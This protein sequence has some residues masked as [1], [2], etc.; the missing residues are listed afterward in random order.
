MKSGNPF[1]SHE[2]ATF[3]TAFTIR[4]YLLRVGKM[5]DT[6]PPILTGLNLPESVN[7]NSSNPS[8][9][10]TVAATDDISGV[11]SVVVFLD[12]AISATDASGNVLTLQGFYLPRASDGSFTLTEPLSPFASPGTYHVSEIQVQD[13]AGN[14][15]DYR[16]TDLAAL[17]LNTTFTLSGSTD[18]LS[19]VPLDADKNEGNSGSTPFTFTVSR[20]GDT[21]STTTVNWTVS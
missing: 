16:S 4:F 19:I 21:S 13:K 17:G 12:K 11:N 7:L 15:H 10:F 5:P 20:S 9:T 3:H 1:S 6:S 8:A 18:L 2:N 14:L